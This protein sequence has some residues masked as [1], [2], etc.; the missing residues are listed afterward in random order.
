MP[1]FVGRAVLLVPRHGGSDRPVRRVTELTRLLAQTVPQ[2]A[3]ATLVFRG[4]DDEGQPY[5]EV[6]HSNVASLPVGGRYGDPRAR[7]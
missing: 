6:L 3:S 4:P 2:A 7:G 1:R 5:F